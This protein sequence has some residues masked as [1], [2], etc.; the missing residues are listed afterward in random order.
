M[1]EFQTL[2][3]DLNTTRLI[4][5]NSNNLKLKLNITNIATEIAK[6]SCDIVLFN[7]LYIMFKFI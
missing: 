7:I 4:E 1:R 6:T 2:K 5:V 3:S